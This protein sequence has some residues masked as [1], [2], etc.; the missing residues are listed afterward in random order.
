MWGGQEPFSGGQIALRGEYAAP[1]T[2]L[3]PGEGI[4]AKRTGRHVKDRT[5]TVARRVAAI[6]GGQ[7]AAAARPKGHRFWRSGLDTWST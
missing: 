5:R 3:N 2:T 4:E 1:C 6:G 7:Q